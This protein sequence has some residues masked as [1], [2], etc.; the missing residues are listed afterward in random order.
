MGEDMTMMLLF[1][2]A[3]KVAYV[4]KAFYH[5]IKLNSNAMSNVY[6]DRHKEELKHNVNWISEKL[7]SIE[8]DLSKEISFLKLEA[9]FPFLLMG[10]SQ[11]F[12]LWKEWYPE[13]NKYILQNQTISIR[14]RW[15]QWCAWKNLF[16]IVW[17]YSRLFKLAYRMLY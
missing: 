13:A 15:L 12:K 16:G 2:Y 8:K 14:N 10:D 4:P 11:S 1:A 6:T 5:Y 9:K 17:V 3:K 7:I